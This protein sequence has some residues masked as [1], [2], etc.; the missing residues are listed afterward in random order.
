MS[1]RLSRH[2]PA[3]LLPAILLAAH[4]AFA[5]DAIALR[6]WAAPPY[7]APAATDA[8]ES[9]AAKLRD[10]GRTGR[11]TLALPSAALP[12]IAIPPCR[13]ADTRDGSFPA[14]F[15]PPSLVG[16]AT[17]RTFVIPSGPCPGLPADAGA[18]SLNFTVVAPPGTP[19][20]GYLSVWPTGGTQPI[21]STLNFT[22]NSILANAAV[23]PAG[24]G[25][26]INVFVN[27]STD[28][29]IDVNGYY[30]GTGVVTA[31]N[32]L[33]GDVTLA[34]GSNITI[35]PAGQ[36]L[37]IAST[38]GPG[39]VLP[40]GSANQ[41]LRSNGSAWLASSLLTNDGSTIAIA[42]P[43]T[44]SI[45][46]GD[47]VI[48]STAG[49]SNAGVKGVNDNATGFGVRGDSTSGTGVMGVSSAANNAGAKGVN[50]HAAGFGVRGDSTNGTGVMGVSSSASN[51]GVKGVNNTLGGSG[52]WGDTTAGTGVRGSSTTGTA[53]SGT[54]SSGWAGYF[55][56]NVHVA[57]TL[58]K[59]GGSFQIDHP[60]D[61]ENKFLYHSFV[62][63]PDM[64]N[65]YDGVAMTDDRG[66]ATVELPEWF[67]ALNRD[68]RYQ[69]TVIGG[70]AWAR[71]RIAR[72]IEDNRFVIETD[73]PATEVSWQ[74]TGIRKDAFA[75]KNRIPVEEMKSEGQRGKYLNPEAHGKA[76]ELR[77]GD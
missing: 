13:I 5:D 30:A 33:T 68:F 21:V 3:G 1:V 60:L 40:L 41:T 64:K 75:E 32:T 11:Q 36:T 51:A 25:G 62:E 43:L 38:G 70:G 65:I 67:E 39:G 37:T 76:A 31:L 14:N 66:Y 58:S 63:S 34:Q 2:L 28:L 26:G 18:W 72:K 8:P 22:S 49:A 54:S 29:I 56:G 10:D 50:D 15:G 74:V 35:T 69:L 27:F 20:G 24:T 47:G 73:A 71:A 9:P 23:I 77:I 42:G 61:P 57:G 59:T 48:G 46:S 55:T 44:V 12:F 52:V 53:I 17:G 45:F 7:W 19:P 4:S 6:S 16:G